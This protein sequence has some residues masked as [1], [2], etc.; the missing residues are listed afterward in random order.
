M[1]DSQVC[2]ILLYIGTSRDSYV[3]TGTTRYRYLR[4]WLGTV[5]P[6]KKKGLVCF[7]TVMRTRTEKMRIRM[8]IREKI[9]VRMRIL[10]HA[11]IE[12]W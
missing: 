4:Y 2:T 8:H 10:I 3:A 5:L 9:L 11:L 7:Y 1:T 12:L 6:D